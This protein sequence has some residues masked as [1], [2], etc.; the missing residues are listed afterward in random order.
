MDNCKKNFNKENLRLEFL[1]FLKTN[2]NIDDLKNLLF[3]KGYIKS[4]RS[5]FKSINKDFLL[6]LFNSYEVEMNFRKK[7]LF[8]GKLSNPLS[9]HGY[10]FIKFTPEERKM[11]FQVINEIKLNINRN[12]IKK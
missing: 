9:N 6:N 10:Y 12:K 7:A 3:N 4:K 1:N 2:E 8:F 11:I 5:M